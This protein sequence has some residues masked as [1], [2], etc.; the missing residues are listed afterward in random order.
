MAKIRSIKRK[1]NISEAAETEQKIPTWAWYAGAGV[2]ALLLILGLFY[3]DSQSL[4]GGVNT[5]RGIDEARVFP[6]PGAGHL[7]GDIEYASVV[8]PG[9]PHN[10]TWQNCG[11][12]NEPIRTENAVHSMEH[13][14]V[15]IAYDPELPAEQ[16]EKLRDLVRDERSRLRTFYVL[17]PKEGLPS[18]IVATAWRVQLEVDDAFD[19]RLPDFMERFHVGQYTPERGAACSGGVGDPS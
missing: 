4:R 10:P 3:L 15:W 11:I 16:V 2:V 13:G 1:A 19:E 9:G 8:P 12:Y 6:D 5:T 14:A 7:N 17:A 18:P